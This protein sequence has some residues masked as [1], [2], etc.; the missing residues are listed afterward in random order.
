LTVGLAGYERM[1]RLIAAHSEHPAVENDLLD[2][3]L[4]APNV[5]NPETGAPVWWVSD[6]AAWAEVEAQM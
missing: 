6:E 1:L 2:E 4:T 3:M 5:V